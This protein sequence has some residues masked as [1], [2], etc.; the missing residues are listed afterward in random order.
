MLQS[1]RA[2][3]DMGRSLDR[4][5]FSCSCLWHVF[6]WETGVLGLDLLVLGLL[7]EKVWLRGE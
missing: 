2:V 6:A 3:V 4:A 5:G 1:L 7:R